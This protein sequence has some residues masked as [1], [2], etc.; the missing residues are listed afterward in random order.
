MNLPPEPEK[1]TAAFERY[2]RKPTPRRL[3]RVVALCQGEVWR[4]ALRVTGSEEDA[5]DVCQDVFLSLLLSPPAAGSV[6]SAMGYLVYRVLTL[7]AR[8]SR[9]DA[10]RRK[11]EAAAAQSITCSELAEA[12]VEALRDAL[13]SLP[14]R[15]R[16]AIELHYLAGCTHREIAALTGASERTVALDLQKGRDQL[17]L[18]LGQG[19][20]GLLATLAGSEAARAQALP[21]ALLDSLDKIVKSGS[22]LSP[23]GGGA[24]CRRQQG[25]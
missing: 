13:E 10:R 11:R 4:V 6:R 2:L 24:R 8:R 1:A 23:V 3:A 25:D 19:A 15:I 16:A 18:R 12:D 21:Q 5:A 14:A 9:A 17:R 22:A 20:L 7:A